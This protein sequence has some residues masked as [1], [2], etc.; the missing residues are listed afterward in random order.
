MPPN[1]SVHIL[2]PEINTIYVKSDSGD[3]IMAQ[4]FKEINNGK[5]FSK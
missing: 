5:L 4:T 1:H 3:V 2:I